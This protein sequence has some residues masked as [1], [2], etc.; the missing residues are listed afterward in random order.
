M[1]A[2]FA[3]LP[4]S[5]RRELARPDILDRSAGF[6]ADLKKGSLT[7]RSIDQERFDRDEEYRASL[8]AV[9]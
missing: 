7:G 2:I 5:A 4:E 9:A 6:L 8:G 1:R 3:H